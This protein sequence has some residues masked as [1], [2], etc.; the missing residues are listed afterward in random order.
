MKAISDRVVDIKGKISNKVH[1]AFLLI[2][3][4]KFSL[5]RSVISK[6]ISSGNN[7]N[8][9]ISWVMF[10]TLVL[11]WRL[12]NFQMSWALTSSCGGAL[13]CGT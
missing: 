1:L 6:D 11:S 9:F 7:R 8:I 12:C 4:I 5:V 13:Q 10:L 3:G 2:M